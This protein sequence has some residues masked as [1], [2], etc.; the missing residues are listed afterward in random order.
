MLRPAQSGRW[1]EASRRGHSRNQVRGGKAAVTADLYGCLHEILATMTGFKSSLQSPA[2]IEK[3]ARAT[4]GRARLM[5]FVADGESEASLQNCL[6][7]LS[8][9]DATIKRGGIA[10]AI[11]ILGAERSP[12]MI[13]VDI[14]G[15]DLPVSRVHDLAEVCEPGV[16]VIAIGDRNEIGL[17]RD[18]LQAG[19]SDYIVKPLTA[20]LIARALSAAAQASG[21]RHDQPEA[22]KDGRRHRRPGRRRDD[23]DRG[24]PGMASRQS[25][26][27]PGRCSS[28]STCRTATAR[29]RSTSSRR[30]GCARRWSTRRASIA[31]CSNG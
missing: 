25:A 8:F 9:P 26:K 15:V 14:S 30:P 31:S 11:E 17:Y 23:D 4:A 27:P 5:A 10:K 1:R 20:Q 16:T 19:V 3:A 6:S 18:L 24:Q 21:S 28:I 22:R 2:P 13:I 7:Q 29:W 12:D